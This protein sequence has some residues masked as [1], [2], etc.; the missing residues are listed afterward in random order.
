MDFCEYILYIILHYILHTYTI[1]NCIKV[2]KYYIKILEFEFNSQYFIGGANEYNKIKLYY[3]T[4]IYKNQNSV[5][6]NLCDEANY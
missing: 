3:F 2:T 4:P 5:I 1:D 6:H